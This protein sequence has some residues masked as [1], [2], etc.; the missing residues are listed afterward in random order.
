MKKSLNL[1]V[2]LPFLSLIFPTQFVVAQEFDAGLLADTLNVKIENS[3]S[4]ISLLNRLKVTG[5]VQAQWQKA[6]T[7]GISSFSGGNFPKYSDNRFGIRRGRVKFTYENELSTFVVQLDAT[8]KG[9]GVKDA[10]LAVREPWAE[11]ATLTTGV[12]DRPF[13]YEISYSS[14]SRETPERSRLFQSLFPGERDLGAKLTLQPKKGTRFDFIKLDAGLFAGNG[15]NAEFDTRKD[16]IGRLGMSKANKAE[17]FKYGLGV[18]YYNGGTFQGTKFIYSP[19]TL[20]D[21]STLGFVVDSTSTN[22]YEFARRQYLGADLQLSLF[23]PIGLSS[24]R[25]EYITGKQPG[26]KSSNVS[27]ASGTA[28]DYDTY[29]REFNGGYVYYIQNIGQTKHQFVAKYDWF[30]PN[31]KVAG[32]EIKSKS[33]DGKSTGLSAADIKYSTIGLGW[34]YRFNTHIKFTLYYDI[35]NNETTGISGANSTNNYTK[36]LKDNVFTFRVQY[37][38]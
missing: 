14:S 11:F 26:G 32:D 19:G 35:V 16:F 25:A 1:L 17:S 29:L 38:F 12:F 21:G 27:I 20:A 5:Y 34:N 22:K 18:S 8:E 2:L 23:S 30:D 4:D 36:D 31:T 7:A 28:P 24:I 3:R 10:Y 6:D 9:V 13:G 15:I 37:K 33:S